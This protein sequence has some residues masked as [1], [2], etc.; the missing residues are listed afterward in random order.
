MSREPKPA[1]DVTQILLDVRAGHGSAAETLF[2]LVY[3]ELRAMAA[4]FFCDQPRSHTL[5]PTALVHEAYVKLVDPGRVQARDRAQFFALAATVMRNILVDYA[6]AKSREKRGGDRTRITLHEAVTPSP[7]RTLDL[8]ALDEALQCLAALDQRQARV[9]EL[10][11]FGGLSIEEAAD[12]LGLSRAT[13][14]EEWRCARAFLSQQLR[15]N[16]LP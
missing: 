10:R 12:V 6:R 5:Q 3:Q 15:G 7:E 16:E 13:L 1:A 2:P 9:V 4:A 8:L 11:F 14:T